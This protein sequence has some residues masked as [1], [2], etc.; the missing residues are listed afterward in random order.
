MTQETLEPQERLGGLLWKESPPGSSI[1]TRLCHGQEASASFN[2]NVCDGHTELSMC[3]T[4]HYDGSVQ[5]L[6][7]SAKRAWR[8]I[9]RHHPEC[10]IE[11]STGMELEQTMTFVDFAGRGTQGKAEEDEWLGETWEVIQAGACPDVA[12]WK[13]AA[14]MTYRRKL[15]TRGKRSKMYLILAPTERLALPTATDAYE[16]EL[17]P[18]AHCFIWNVSHAITDGFS[19]NVFFNTYLELVAGDETVHDIVDTAPLVER[20]PGTVLSAYARAYR[21]TKADLILSNQAAAEQV[22]LYEARVGTPS[23]ERQAVSST[24]SIHII[25]SSHNH[26]QMRESIALQPRPDQAH[27]KHLTTCLLKRLPASVSEKV[28]LNLKTL[29]LPISITY[30]GAASLI[31]S[32]RILFG[33]GSETG[34]LLGLTRNARRW[35]RTD[36]ASPFAKEG[37]ESDAPIPMATDVVY[38]WIPFEGLDLPGTAE[39]STVEHLISLSCRIKQALEPHLSSPHYI[40]QHHLMALAFMKGLRT[41]YEST[42]QANCGPQAPGFSPGGAWSVRQH[43]PASRGSQGLLQRKFLYQTGRQVSPSPW[44][45]MYSVGGRICFHLGF[46]EKYWDGEDMVKLIRAT[47]DSVAS[48]ASL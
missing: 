21:P 23:A 9:R 14:K 18:D 17:D 33:T 11:L 8:K 39:T 12:T 38:L 1:F 30:I 16:D 27:R 10:G 46:D 28:I 24:D 35:V 34:A 20:L 40:S 3:L 29:A 15:P 4:F 6:T 2:Q 37:Q 32:I 31:L 26:F 45:S 42:K 43:F 44:I 36:P 25:T 13:D 47:S 19:F 5:N 41:A 48:I 7:S 22:R